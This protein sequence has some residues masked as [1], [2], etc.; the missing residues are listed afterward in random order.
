MVHRRR[1]PSADEML[2]F[3]SYQEFTFMQFT[4]ITSLFSL[5]ALCAGFA[6]IPAV[7]AKPAEPL[8]VAGQVTA[9]APDSTL[10]EP[11]SPVGV[12]GQPEW[13]KSRRF[14]NTR[15]HIQRD[16]WEIAV[17]QWWR[18]QLSHGDWAH[19]FQEEIEI[20]LP[21]RFQLD[22]YYDW[23]YDKELK[24]D[25]LDYAAEV[26][27]AFADWGKIWGNPTLYFEYK[28][29]DADRGPD[30]V[31]PK[32][33]FGGDIG[34]NTQWGLNFVFEGETA[35]EKTEEYQVTAGVATALSRSFSVGVE[36]K[37]VHESVEHARS[38]AEQ[39]FLFGPSIQWCPCEKS[40]ID[41][42]ALAGFTE[43]SPDVELWFVGGI[44]FGHGGSS[45]TPHA[46][47]SGR[48]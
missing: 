47:V 7:S 11:T 13:V 41:L 44:E 17:E 3:S 20:G 25:F 19:R 15:V 36:A 12:Y 5:P 21:G 35:G 43:D 2:I 23:T 9:T 30:V 1:L 29:T 4:K 24:S 14:A 39:K 33:L 37:Y 48:R 40:H 6:A 34:K 22:F 38:S 32:I 16:P 10:W 46:P 8:P 26:R 31:E 18:G 27:W 42:V 45:R 28:W